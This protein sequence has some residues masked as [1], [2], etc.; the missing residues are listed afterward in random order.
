MEKI[1]KI[2]LLLALGIIFTSCEKTN[3]LDLDIVHPPNTNTNTFLDSVYEYKFEMVGRCYKD[4]NEYYHL[5]LIEGENQ[6]LHRF[7]AYVT[8]IDKWNLPTQV[9]WECESTW[10]FGDSEVSIVNGTSYADPTVDSVF[11]M[12]APVWGMKGDTVTIQGQ[13][14]FEEGDI[15][16]YDNIKVIL[17]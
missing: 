17:E 5:D 16:L 10:F 1:K 11:C 3:P 7:G 2:I 9:F 8:K 4:P 13:A 6:T 15:I 14:W 12:M